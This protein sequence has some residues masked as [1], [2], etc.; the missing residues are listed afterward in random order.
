MRLARHVALLGVFL[1]ALIVSACGGSGGGGSATPGTPGTEPTVVTGDTDTFIA[2]AATADGSAT[3]TYVAGTPPAAGTGPCLTPTAPLAM[4]VGGSAQIPLTAD[5]PFDSVAVFI[6]GGNGY[7]EI[8]L[9]SALASTD[10]VLTL[11]Q[12]LPG[13]YF[14]ITFIG[15]DPDDYG[16][17]SQILMHTLPVGTG[18]VQV[19]VSWDAASDVDLWVTDPNDFTID[20]GSVSSPEGG[21]LDLDSNPACS[22]DGVNNENITWPT[23]S[24]PTGTYLVQV[25]YFD[26]CGVAETNYTVTVQMSGV[27]PHTFTGSFVGSA[28]D[29]GITTQE[30]TSFDY[31]AGTFALPV[32]TPAA[33]PQALPRTQ[34]APK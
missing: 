20:Y 1:L 10:L 2:L 24:A 16:C 8:V 33:W 14:R 26:D 25:D 7:I 12:V 27:E 15:G 11:Q 4:I 6:S 31:P 23:G 3:G 19:S 17:A 21:T 30:I 22:I 5:A 29:M 13:E 9:P 32:A 34:R 18:D 28:Y